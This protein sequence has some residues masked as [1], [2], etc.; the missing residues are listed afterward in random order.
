[1]GTSSGQKNDN[2]T[3]D[4]SDT[5]GQMALAVHTEHSIQKKK[6]THSSQVH[7]EHSPE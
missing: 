4:L 2:E 6:S 7:M 5:V 3:L 1:M